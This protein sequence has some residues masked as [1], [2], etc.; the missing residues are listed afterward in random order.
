MIQSLS[1]KTCAELSQENLK[2]FSEVEEG[3]VKTG[4]FCEPFLERDVHYVIELV[5]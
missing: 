2:D 4:V 3:S 5:R 1:G